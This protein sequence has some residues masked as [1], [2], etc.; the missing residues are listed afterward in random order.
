V[1]LEALINERDVALASSDQILSTIERAK[2]LPTETEK[3]N[4]NTNRK[5][6]E[7]L[8]PQIEKLERASK[9]PSAM[10]EKFRAM[11]LG[12][13]G[14]QPDLVD[15]RGRERMIPKR[16]STAYRDAMRSYIKNG[17]KT[18]A[19][20][21]GADAAGGY[22]VLQETDEYIAP[23]APAASEIR[24]KCKVIETTKTI[25]LPT[26]APNGLPTTTQ[27][28]ELAAFTQSLPSMGQTQLQAYLNTML[29]PVSLELAE[30]APGLE[31]WMRVIVEAALLE[32]E[33][34]LFIAGSGSGEI[35]GMLS[36]IG[37]GVT[38][39][40]D[41]NGNAVSFAGLSA[42]MGAV[43]AKYLAGASWLMSQSTAITARAAL[44]YS[45]ASTEWT[46]D[47]SGDRLFGFPVCYSA[48]MQS[49]TRGNTPV[50]FG[51]LAMGYIIGDRGGPAIRLKVL[52]QM[53]GVNGTLYWLL[54]RRTDARVWVQEAL[55]PLQIS[56]S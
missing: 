32:Q 39:E 42:L 35:Q 34:A 22:A 49:A 21:E 3:S 15:A 10:R 45:G 2:R 4:L 31:A 36:N 20:Y 26:T 13:I 5:K 53:F 47:A 8:T 12:A 30:D 55:Q 1:T 43:K 40:P 16:F 28:A 19:L 33:D 7:T 51:N 14:T 46:R 56:A 37:V 41:G 29:A 24:S 44:A 17:G 25:L 23:I 18:A 38:A 48:S 52:D 6:I 27:T 50:I 54:Y 11:G 9:D